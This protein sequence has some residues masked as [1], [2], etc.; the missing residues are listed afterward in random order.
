[1]VMDACSAPL[2]AFTKPVCKKAQLV[3]VNANLIYT[4]QSKPDTYKTRANSIRPVRRE[5]RAEIHSQSRL[6][7]G[8][9]EKY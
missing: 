8:Q 4:M 9:R 6:L 7:F 5:Q 1:M 3:R 2:N